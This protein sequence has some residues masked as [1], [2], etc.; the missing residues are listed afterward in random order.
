[1]YIN[2]HSRVLCVLPKY[3]F[4]L[5]KREFSTEYQAFYYS[6]KKNFKNFFFFDS[7]EINKNTF[8]INSHLIQTCKKIKPDFIFFSI[9]YNEIYIETLREIKKKFNP[10]LFNWCSDDSWRFKEHSI[11]LAPFFDYMITTEPE[12]HNKYKSHGHKSILTHWGCPDSWITKPKKSKKCKYDVLFIGSSYFNRDKNIN[13]LRKKKINVSCYGYGWK[14]KPLKYSEFRKKVNNSKISINFSK[15]RKGVLQTKARIFENTGC[16]SMCIT[17]TSRNLRK[18]FSLSE[19]VDFIT[20]D[21]L[22]KKIKYFLKNSK[23]RD[24]IAQKGFQKCK[25][26]Y[27]YDK[28]VKN[29]FF[30]KKFIKKKNIVQEK[31]NKNSFFLK[32]QIYES[33]FKLSYNFLCLLFN[34]DKAKKII[35]RMIFE[36][37]WRVKGSK[38][39]SKNS[40]VNCVNEIF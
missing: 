20:L 24:A 29:I 40:F 38:T 8:L 26:K 27:T 4:G 15:S 17:Q 31:I 23:K 37:E 33:I 35:K 3:S 22:E 36:F 18:Y 7:L 2:K 21:E 32:K 10:I 6:L 14:N 11:L 16:G 28:I 5:K 12:A 34:K 39:Y 1:M 25:K 9:A 30:K 13:Y 19:V